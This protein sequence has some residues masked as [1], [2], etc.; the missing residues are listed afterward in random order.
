MKQT[1]HIPVKWK[2]TTEIIIL[3]FIFYA[4]DNKMENVLMNESI[5]RFTL[6][7]IGLCTIYALHFLNVQVVWQL[8]LFLTELLHLFI[9]FYVR[10]RCN[11]YFQ[12][13]TIYENC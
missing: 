1:K 11:P 10:W 9:T 7:L 4:I 8:F 2:E 5:K 6:S 3:L 12:N 13:I